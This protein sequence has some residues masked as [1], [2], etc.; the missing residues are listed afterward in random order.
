MNPYHFIPPSIVSFCAFVGTFC[1]IFAYKKRY[2]I[3]SVLANG[4]RT[5]GTVV[6]IRKDP[7]G[8]EGE[9]PVVDFDYPNGSYRHFSTTYTLPCAYHLGQRVEIWYKFNK[10]NRI[11]ALSDDKP[12]SLPKV[13]LIWGIVL[14]LLSY[15]EIIRR[16]ITLNG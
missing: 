16:M 1:L 7:S 3:E 4:I 10:S 9:A 8:K 5:F 12:G 15:P 11:A 2:E 13:L 6:E 14:C